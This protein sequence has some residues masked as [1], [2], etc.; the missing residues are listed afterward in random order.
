MWLLKQKEK[1]L[2]LTFGSGISLRK[3]VIYI[4][5]SEK[6]EWI[7]LPYIADNLLFSR[8]LPYIIQQDIYFTD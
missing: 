4:E 2:R 7:I 1:Q 5:K 8:K 6:Q 3:F